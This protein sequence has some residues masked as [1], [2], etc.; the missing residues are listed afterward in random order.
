M[1]D[2][3]PD[4]ESEL[5]EFGIVVDAEAQARHREELTQVL[6]NAEI[7]RRPRMTPEMR[8]IYANAR[9]KAVSWYA[10]QVGGRQGTS[11]YESLEASIRQDLQELRRMRDEALKR[12]RSSGTLV[13]ERIKKVL[14]RDGKIPPTEVIAIYRRGERIDGYG[15]GPQPE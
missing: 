7:E 12:R 9:G 11:E 3:K 6:S 4:L 15:T 13:A 5:R 1:S 2:E 10:M 8:E 14:L